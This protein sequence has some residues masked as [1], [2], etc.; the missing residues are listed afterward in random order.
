[1]RAILLLLKAEFRR[2][3]LII[4]CYPFE[5]I[6]N[7]FVVSLSFIA[8][9]F[10]I[11]LSAEGS[12]NNI[13]NLFL[14]YSLGIL[15]MFFISEMGMEI[16]NE[17]NLGTLE[18]IYTMPSRLFS[19]ITVRTWI[20][21]LFNIIKLLI[22]VSIFILLLD[23]EIIF[24]I[25]FLLVLFLFMISLS[26]VGYFLSGLTLLFKKTGELAG[27]LQFVFLFIVLI[28]YESLPDLL[29]YILGYIPGAMAVQL[30]RN[31]ELLS[32][33]SIDY[34]LAFIYAISHLIIGIYIFKVFEE[35][36]LRKGTLSTY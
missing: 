20:S 14:S 25:N 28:P 17:A 15:S 8:I 6:T 35:V 2:Y 19:V 1:M 27:I 4:K 16:A 33:I 3:L 9:Y 13:N 26:G 11:G 21:V 30:I 5:P 24:N 29:R 23:I 31:Y 18:R 7:L 10:G 34:L 12:L 22:F 32:V 36:T